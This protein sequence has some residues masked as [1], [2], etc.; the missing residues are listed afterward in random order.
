MKKIAFL[1]IAAGILAFTAC[2]NNKTSEPTRV[3]V[4]TITDS[5]LQAAIAGDY[6]SY[7]GKTVISLGSDFTAKV[8]EYDKDFY[9]WEFIVEPNGQK[10][11]N[12]NLIRKGLDSDVA[13]QAVVDTEEGS[14][15]IKNETFRKDAPADKK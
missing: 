6:K 10:V 15:L 1:A 13:E 4:E 7:D 8:K 11:V 9:K 2:N 5:T 3:E 12:I 14:L